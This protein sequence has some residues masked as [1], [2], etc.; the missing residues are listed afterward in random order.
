MKGRPAL[1]EPEAK[2]KA[3]NALKDIAEAEKMID[4]AQE[5]MGSAYEMLDA[6]MRQFKWPIIDDGE[7][8]VKL[9]ETYSNQVRKVDAQKFRNAVTNDQ[10]WKSIDVSITRAK[11]FLTDKEITALSDVIPSVSQGF[12]LKVLPLET[13]KK[14]R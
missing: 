5:K 10:F 13:I 3:Y 1:T 12:K 2:A 11:E 4:R 9:S 8:I 7:Y 14:G 6:L